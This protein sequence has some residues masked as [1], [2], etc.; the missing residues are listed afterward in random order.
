MVLNRRN[1]VIYIHMFCR[2]YSKNMEN[3]FTRLE[4][5]IMFELVLKLNSHNI[6]VNNL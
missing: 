2:Y 3:K 4:I 5:K 1:I 6:L